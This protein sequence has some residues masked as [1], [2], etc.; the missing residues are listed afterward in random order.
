MAICTY[1]YITCILCIYIYTSWWFQT[2]LKDMLVKFLSSPQVGV[3]FVK[4]YLKPRPCLYIY[5]YMHIYIYTYLYTRVTGKWPAPATNTSW[6][7][8]NSRLTGLRC[9]AILPNPAISRTWG[10]LPDQLGSERKGIQNTNLENGYIN[11]CAV[12]KCWP[13]KHQPNKQL[14]S[15]PKTNMYHGML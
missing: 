8:K 15:L 14:Y 3:N 7:K 4:R 13:P 11:L 1:I 9:R 5:I 2:Q 6:N 10:V 12:G